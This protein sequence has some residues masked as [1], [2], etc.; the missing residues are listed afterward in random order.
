MEK[1]D[2]PR[3]FYVGIDYKVH[4]QNKYFIDGINYFIIAMVLE[5]G[6]WKIALTPHV[7]V[8]SIIFV[9][10]GFGTEDEMTFDERRERFL[11]KP[12]D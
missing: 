3:V 5:K 6:K 1:F 10:Y 4:S 8:G 9:G 7:P 12:I 2:K 11:N